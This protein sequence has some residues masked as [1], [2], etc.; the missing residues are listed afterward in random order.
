M[1]FVLLKAGD[2]DTN[3]AIVGAVIGAY[4]GASGID[5]TW[6]DKVCNYDNQVGRKRPDWLLAKNNM[7]KLNYIIA[8]A[9]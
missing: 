8:N 7:E 1:H 3:A 5:E 4:H 6:V 9:P 2:T